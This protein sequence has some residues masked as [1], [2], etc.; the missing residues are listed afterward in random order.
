MESAHVPSGAQNKIEG[1][2]FKKS[3]TELD[4]SFWWMAK[5]HPLGD[6]N[7]QGWTWYS[8]VILNVHTVSL[9]IWSTATP[10]SYYQNDPVVYLKFWMIP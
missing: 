3:I 1:Y 8:G 5:K 2:K 10:F 7:G 4:E 6:H 9:A